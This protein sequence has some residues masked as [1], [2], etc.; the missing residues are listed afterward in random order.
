MINIESIIVA[1][2]LIADVII[3][4]ILYYDILC[5]TKDTW[6]GRNDN[7]IIVYSWLYYAHTIYK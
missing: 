6:Q 2:L 4:I 7:L 3:I 1:V 5:G